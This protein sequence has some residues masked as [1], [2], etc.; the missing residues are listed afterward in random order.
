MWIYIGFIAFIIIIFSFSSYYETNYGSPIS[1]IG[2]RLRIVK[3]YRNRYQLQKRY[4][5]G[6][7]KTISGRS[8][9]LSN[10]ILDHSV[11]IFYSTKDKKVAENFLDSLEKSVRD[12]N[13]GKK[14]TV[15]VKEIILYT[16]IVEK[17]ENKQ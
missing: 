14:K 11:K 5:P 6:F 16:G 10:D 13:V 1:I 4:W 7:W 3:D 17:K 12:Y 2:H 8:L 9:K 15:V